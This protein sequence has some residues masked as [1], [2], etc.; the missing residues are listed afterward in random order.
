[1]VISN[2]LIKN[3]LKSSGRRATPKRLLILDLL[4]K[5]PGHPDAETL[6]LR[7]RNIDPHISL[8]TVYRTLALLKKE[9]IVEGHR[10]GE[11][12]AHYEAAGDFPHVH[13]TCL[14]C[15]R[16]IEFKNPLLGRLKS[17]LRRKLKADV[18]E[19]HA[20]ARG[21]CARCRKVRH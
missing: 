18:R 4:G 14:K 16:V 17:E 11:S 12:H 2:R 10:L 8:A 20:H 6:F 7:A 9:G 21:F 15:G 19:F 1:M 13:F 5:I 3:A